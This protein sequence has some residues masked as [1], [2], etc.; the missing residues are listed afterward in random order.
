[1]KEINIQTMTNKE[2]LKELKTR[3]IEKKIG[4]EELFRLLESQEV[5]TEYEVVDFSKLTPENWKKA[6]QDLEK[7][8]NYQAEVK[9]W[10]SIDDE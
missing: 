10:D 4:K 2:L 1:M 3:V 6:Y 8:K 7:D 5:I 9:L